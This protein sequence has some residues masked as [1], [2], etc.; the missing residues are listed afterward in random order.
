VRKNLWWPSLIILPIFLIITP[1]F[2]KAQDQALSSPATI[3]DEIFRVPHVVRHADGTTS[4][5]VEKPFTLAQKS[6]VSL[7][8]ASKKSRPSLNV[9]L[10][11]EDNYSKYQTSGSLTNLTTIG[12][13]S[14]TRTLGFEATTVLTPGKY[15][16][17]IQWAEDG[18]FV[19]SPA[20]GL[21]LIAQGIILKIQKPI[22]TP[23]PTF[24]KRIL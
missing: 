18:L 4:Q 13:F 2:A 5:G 22:A 24:W 12:D 6:N 17:L 7:A 11:D 21:R 10:L 20:V 8:I 1:R 23:T 15:V 9:Y 14:K 3:T 16:L 19:T